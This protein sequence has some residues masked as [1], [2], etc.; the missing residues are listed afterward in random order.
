MSIISKNPVEVISESRPSLKENTV[1]QYGIHLNKLKRLFESDDYDFLKN[2]NEVM[3]KIK[4]LHYLS[5]RNILNAIIVFLNV[6][7]D[8]EEYN[9][10]IK[11]YVKIRDEFNDK[12]VD[13]QN[14][15]V[16]SEKQSKNFATTEEIFGMLK[17]MEEEL[18]PIKKKSKDDMT[19]KDL[20]LLQ[21]YTL[22][23]IYS[24]MPFRNDVAE[25]E[26]IRKDQYNKLTNE[27]KKENN[28]LVVPTK[29]KLF[30]VL[31]KYKTSA[32]YEELNIT[33]EDNELRKIL[34]YYLKING[35]GILFKSS[36][37][38][39]L[40][41]TEISKV[42]L[43][44]SKKY[45]NKSISTTLLRKSYLSSKYAKVKEEMASDAQMMAHSV[46]TQQSV[47]V[48]KQKEE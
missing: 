38:K 11:E 35:M 19:K 31:N 47:Y 21:A 26:A 24:R 8:D 9:E 2:S 25:M 33:I 1:K 23:S 12:Y 29:E 44:Y 42:L 27:D 40:T 5:Q 13:E 30:F 48:K 17:K 39:T 18:K 37:G 20:Q 45:M 7:D 22:F 34:R 36:T 46:A 32:K 41:R 4:D 28:Y 10:L 14:T 15:G 6:I 3:N 16:I 43:K